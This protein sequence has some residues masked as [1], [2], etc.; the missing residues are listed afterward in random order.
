MIQLR[1]TEKHYNNATPLSTTETHCKQNLFVRNGTGSCSSGRAPLVDFVSSAGWCGRAMAKMVAISC[2]C[3]EQVTKQKVH[4]MKMKD[5]FLL[6]DPQRILQ[7]QTP[8]TPHFSLGWIRNRGSGKNPISGVMATRV[9]P[10]Q[11]LFS[12]E[13]M[14]PPAAKWKG[15]SEAKG[16][17]PAP[18][19]EDI[20]HGNHK[21]TWLP[22]YLWRTPM[23]L[24][25]PRA[26]RLWK[27]HLQ[28]VPLDC[29]HSD[30]LAGFD[31]AGDNG[32]DMISIS[33]TEDAQAMLHDTIARKGGVMPHWWALAI[34]K[35]SKGQ[36]VKNAG[37]TVMI[38][39]NPEPDAFSIVAP[40]ILMNPE[41]DAFSIVAGTHVLPENLGLF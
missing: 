30:M 1:F 22:A 8:R 36:E 37:S 16:A 41:P 14:A 32:V 2:W 19:L 26:Q 13:G 34:T 31:G 18:P 6:A 3:V 10:G 28:N 9:L 7:L 39:M 21:A 24:E 12:D 40:V 25:M 23:E 5:G 29:L 35:N 4:A 20:C 11:P 33:I 17:E 27:T 15:K 38:L